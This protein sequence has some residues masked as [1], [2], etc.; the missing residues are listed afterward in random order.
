MEEHVGRW[1]HTALDHLTQASNKAF[2][3]HLSDVQGSIGTMFRAAGGD[4][5][6]RIASAS[7]QAIGGPRAW[8]ARL[9]GSGERAE[10]PVLD[11]EVVALPSTVS[12]FADLALNRDLFVWLAMLAAHYRHTGDWVADNM[13]ASANALVTFPGF[14]QRYLGLRDAHL[15]QRPDTTRMKPKLNAAEQRVQAA[16]LGEP[17]STATPVQA[18][19]VTPVWLWMTVG[20]RL[21][22]G[23]G[24]GASPK[25]TEGGKPPSP[26]DDG[27][28][29]RTQAAPDSDAH[30]A[31]V[32]PFR[33]ESLMS[34][35]E[36]VRMDRATDDEDDG[37]AVTAANDMDKLSVTQDGETLA[38]R[39]KFDLDLPSASHDEEPLGPGQRFPEWDYKRGAL[40]PEYC[41]V[42]EL[43]GRSDSQYTPSPALRRM[44][45]HMSRRLE[46][47]RDAPRMQHGQEQG[48]DI[49][50]DAW[51]RLRAEEGDLRTWRS[52][53]P[54]VYS[55]RINGERS[56][57]TLLLADLSLSTDAYANDQMRVIDVIR[58]AMYAFG[59]ALSAVGDPFAMWGFSSVRRHQVRLQHLKGFDEAWGDTTRNRVGAVRPGF[60]TRMGAAIRHA[61][62][63]LSQRSERRRLLMLLTD[64]KPNDLDQYEGR[65]GLE[66]TKRAIHEARQAGLVPFCVTIDEA[67]HDYLPLLFGRQGYV[68]VHRPQDLAL[69]LTQAWR[70]IAR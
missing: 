37:S 34:W 16:L 8:M 48:D 59:E 28:R 45:K 41:V 10:L 31:M 40:Q 24:S 14:R 21:Q 57:A 11:S 52:D 30:N 32:L 61:T 18:A 55:R 5:A 53:T 22:P 25:P 42:Q 39:I 2:A 66:D 62:M 56:L 46:V 13:A 47:L 33:G 20:D 50:L 36:M 68:W 60:Y 58:D 35:S 12:V 27:R 38:S 23:T 26:K 54:A 3:V 64:G 44:A 15:A 63:Q 65:Y 67:A 7:E 51:V 43:M 6:L 69:R 1:W 70:T 17:T 19:D 49:D 29:R 9:A 4:A